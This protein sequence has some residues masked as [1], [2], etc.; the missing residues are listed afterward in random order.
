[1]SFLLCLLFNLCLCLSPSILSSATHPPD[2]VAARVFAFLKEFASK[3]LPAMDL[4][5]FREQC[6]GVVM[7]KLEKPRSLAEEA[8]EFWDPI[9]DRRVHNHRSNDNMDNNSSSSNSNNK[10]S[11]S[12]SG[13]SST[14]FSAR[15]AALRSSRLEAAAISKVSKQH[16]EAALHRW[17]L[18]PQAACLQVRVVGRAFVAGTS[19]EAVEGPTSDQPPPPQGLAKVTIIGMLNSEVTC[20]W[21]GPVEDCATPLGEKETYPCFVSGE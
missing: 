2:V 11:G 9:S 3:T 10:N 21:E 13:S 18:G 5:E 1:L 6:E 19:T 20:V 8:S 14:V 4:D 16:A 7:G 17:L 12:D 15:E